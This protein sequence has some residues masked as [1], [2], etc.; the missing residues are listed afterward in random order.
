MKRSFD[1]PRDFLRARSVDQPFV[2]YETRPGHSREFS[3]EQDFN[4]Y[5][6]NRFSSALVEALVP[7]IRFIR[8]FRSPGGEVINIEPRLAESMK[9]LKEVYVGKVSL[10]DEYDKK[11]R[12]LE[13]QNIRLKRLIS[14][15]GCKS[16]P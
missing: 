7:H 5:L 12:D 10:F 6:E 8:F 16:N 14:S 3:G 11:I 13:I 15:F 9:G 2:E 4:K 1:E